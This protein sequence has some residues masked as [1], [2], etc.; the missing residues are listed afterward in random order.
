MKTTIVT[1]EEELADISEKI[2]KNIHENRKSYDS[3]HGHDIMEEV[4]RHHQ[5]IIRKAKLNKLNN[6]SKK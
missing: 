5:S 6:E 4:I 2:L 1:D 3:A